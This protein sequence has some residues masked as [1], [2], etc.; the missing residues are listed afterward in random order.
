MLRCHLGKLQ[1]QQAQGAKDAFIKSKY[2]LWPGNS[3]SITAEQQGRGIP[4]QSCSD[5]HKATCY[6]EGIF[7]LK[8]TLNSSSSV[9]TEQ[10]DCYNALSFGRG[11]FKKLSFSTS[12][13]V[14]SL[15]HSGSD[16]RE[17]SLTGT[18]PSVRSSARDQEDVMRSCSRQLRKESRQV[19]IILFQTKT[20]KTIEGR[21]GSWWMF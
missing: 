13:S 21:M 2:C 1:Q 15:H 5:Q 18:G 16:R 6:R 19:V 4:S 20:S 10:G 12:C 9:F 3:P 7:D 14:F 8:N 11:K 17:Q